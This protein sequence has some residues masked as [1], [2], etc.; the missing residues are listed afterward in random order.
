MPR[1]AGLA[2]AAILGGL[3]VGLG[4]FGAHGLRS[5]L[6]AQGLSPAE[7]A[8]LLETWDTGAR[9][10]MYHA[11][12]LVGVALCAERCPSRMWRAVGVCFVAGTAVFSGSLYALVLTNWRVFGAIVPIGGVAL[13][14]G[15]GL[16]ALTAMSAPAA[17]RPG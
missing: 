15:W 12:A 10:H 6:A 8:R 7:Q 2:T 1:R 4:A 16:W 17:S 3:A 5:H 13:I 11:L 9:Y 14:V